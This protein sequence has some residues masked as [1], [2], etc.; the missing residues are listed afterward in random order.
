M[1]LAPLY[2]IG[3]THIVFASFATHTAL[4]LTPLAFAFGKGSCINAVVIHAAMYN[5]Y[6]AQEAGLFA[7][8]V[9][10]CVEPHDV[11]T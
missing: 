11:A 8:D 7:N 3:R 5:I 2:P 9:S 4:T 1:A 10:P 6:V